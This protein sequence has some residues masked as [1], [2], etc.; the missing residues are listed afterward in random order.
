ML[1][2]GGFIGHF[3]AQLKSKNNTGK[4]DERLQQ[5][6]LEIEKLEASVKRVS[7]ERET[8]REEKDAVNIKLS[9]AS[10]TIT[11]LENKLLEERG[12][13]EKI[14][15]KFTKEFENLANKILDSKSEKFTKQNKENIDTA[16]DD[17][18]RRNH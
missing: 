5:T 3:I 4:L 6:T 7:Q 18:R 13:L 9:K 12:E 1:A 17:A 2:L 8:I 16:G 11:H 14:Q 15:E 10:S